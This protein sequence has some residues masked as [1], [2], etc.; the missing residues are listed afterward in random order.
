MCLK[1]E[2]DLLL[3]TIIRMLKK[4]GILKKIRFINGSWLCLFL[5]PGD[6]W[7][8]AEG[9]YFENLGENL[10][11]C[12]ISFAHIPVYKFLFKSQQRILL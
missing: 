4:P 12:K 8:C 6:L 9:Q 10:C 2:W 1:S 3:D 7:I 11:I 5:L